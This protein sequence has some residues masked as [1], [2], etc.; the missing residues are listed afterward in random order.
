MYAA[1]DQTELGDRGVNAS[2]G[3]KQ[4]ISIAR[5]VYSEADVFLF[6]DPLSA[7]D[8]KVQQAHSLPLPEFVSS[9]VAWDCCFGGVF[10][11]WSLQSALAGRSSAF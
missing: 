6:D 8:A 9:G 7:L 4:R 1:G 11:K 5:A 3:Q 10:F 2:G